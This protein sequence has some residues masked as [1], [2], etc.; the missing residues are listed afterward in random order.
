MFPEQRIFERDG[1]ED[2]QQHYM[3]VT[4]CRYATNRF[5][6]NVYWIDVEL[7]VDNFV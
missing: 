1:R 5:P 4:P 3:A 6:S 7:F 2:K